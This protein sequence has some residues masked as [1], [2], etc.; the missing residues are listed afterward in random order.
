M[1]MG[2]FVGRAEAAERIIVLYSSS[3]NKEGKKALPK[4]KWPLGRG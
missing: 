1:V 4:L 3:E 2:G